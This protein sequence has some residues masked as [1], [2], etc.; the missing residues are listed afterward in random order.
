MRLPPIGGNVPSH[1]SQRALDFMRCMLPEQRRCARVHLPIQTTVVFHELSSEPQIGF[2]RDMSMLGAFCYC[3]QRPS[4]GD[5]AQ[6]TF[7]FPD[8]EQKKA[9]CEGVIV[10]VEEFAPGAAIGV[11]IEF[12]RYEVTRPQKMEEPE[13]HSDEAPFI[14]W[15]V[16]MVE[17]MLA[18]AQ[19][20]MLP[21]SECAQAA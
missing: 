19:R 15:T 16:D 11:A 3:S 1:E 8:D 20:S 9:N 14:G 17:R 21:S 10:R 7:A 4:V 5:H 6:L 13:P 12:T 18:K 2:L